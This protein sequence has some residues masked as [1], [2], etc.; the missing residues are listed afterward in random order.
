MEGA[1]ALWAYVGAFIDELRRS[2]VRHLA[3]SPGSRSTPLVLMAAEHGG[4]RLWRHIDERSA[5]FFALGLAR[6]LDEP[7]ALLCSSGT[8]AANFFPAI[9]EAHYDRVPLVVLTADRPHEV[10]D[11][12]AP[13]TIDQIR[14]YG[15]HVK[16][17]VDMALPEGNESAL[18]YARSAAAR[19]TA[20]AKQH[21]AGPVHLNFPFREPLVP[22]PVSP[23]VGSSVGL[24]GRPGELMYTSVGAGVAKLGADQVSQLADELAARRKGL[25]VCGP[26]RN[27]ALASHV[28]QLAEAIGYPILADPLSGVRYGNH[29]KTWVIDTYDALLR[30]ERIQQ[31]YVPDVVLRFG[32]LPT[33]KALTLYLQRH[34]AA[35]HIVVDEGAGWRDPG[36]L[37]S[38]MIHADALSVCSKLV[39]S[40]PSDLVHADRS[41]GEAWREINHKAKSAL[42]AELLSFPELFEGRLFYELAQMLPDQA[43]LY[44]GNSMPVRDLDSFMFSRHGQLRCYANRGANGIDG[45]VSSAFG[46]AAGSQHPTVLVIGDLSFYHDMNGLL[47]AKIHNL[48]LTIILVNNDGGGIFSFLPQASVTE[49]F[50]PLFGT[51]HGLDFAQAVVMYGGRFERVFD[52]DRF[53]AA[54]SEGMSQG[55]LHVIEVPTVRSSN[56]VMHQDA[57]KAVSH[58]VA[59]RG[60]VV[61]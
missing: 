42:E 58:A 45:V 48:N 55:G 7:V 46:A 50:E 22:Q 14:I 25:I 24:E 51:P 41:W 5:G 37:A 30:D 38:Q 21:P 54:V 44:V 17:F 61:G 23:S 56:R 57:W 10:R 53:R 9:I 40:L 28:V 15:E 35:R 6:V 34:R 13:Q 11:S 27:D 26:Q 60:G 52:W 39:Q 32:A 59:K 2:G 4:I 3:F 16:W 20:T 31:E 18:R 8:A 47:A 19:A 33:S 1:Q 12:G 29:D 43:T 49:H 36:R